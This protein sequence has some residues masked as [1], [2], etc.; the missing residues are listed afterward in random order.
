LLEL[1][2]SWLVKNTEM[3]QM[4]R[5]DSLE[6]MPAYFPKPHSTDRAN[7]SSPIRKMRSV[8]ASCT[9]PPYTP[10][11]R[12][13]SLHSTWAETKATLFGHL[14]GAYFYHTLNKEHS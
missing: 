14:V 10:E 11:W 8:M 12:S 3:Y 13:L 4:L 7:T 6:I 5:T 2:T 9:E 1:E